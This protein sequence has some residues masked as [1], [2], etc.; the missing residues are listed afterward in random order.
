MLILNALG[1]KNVQ[2]LHMVP[3]GLYKAHS[4]QTLASL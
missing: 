2:T 1:C 3:P 4:R